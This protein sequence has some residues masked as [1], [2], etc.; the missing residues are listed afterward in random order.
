AV[1]L[2]DSLP[3]SGATRT[4]IYSLIE[5][6]GRPPPEGTGGM[7]VWRAVTPDYF[8][9]LGIPILRGRAF[10]ERDRTGAENPVLLSASLTRRLFPDDDPLGKRIWAGGQEQARLTVIGVVGD[11]KNSGITSGNDPEYYLVR[12]QMPD[13]GLGN[14][15]PPEATRRASVIIRTS[16]NP[17][18]ITRWV[19]GEISALDPTLPVSIERMR[20][21]VGELAQRPRFNAVLLGLFAGAGL[22]LA[23]VGL[24]GVISFLVEQ[25]TQEIGVRVALGA[26]P[27]E[28]TKMVL[29]HA[30]RWTAA[31]A[32]LGVAGSLVAARLLSTLLFQI[33]A[34][35]PAPLGGALA[36]LLCVALLAAWIPSRRAALVDPMTALRQ[37]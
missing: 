14:R 15:M 8:A 18:T 5:V 28:I 33:P 36:L 30:A 16:A 25:R 20:Q 24:Y 23:A 12:K 13:G 17:M 29:G 32:M 34:R 37:E 7:V 35:D 6:E 27:G 10:E 22:L 21:R 19:R 9:A 26:T 2:S 1:A 4:M 11:V 3:P 31:G